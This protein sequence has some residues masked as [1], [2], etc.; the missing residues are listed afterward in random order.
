MVVHSSVDCPT[1][2]KYVRIPFHHPQQKD[3]RGK[4]EK[5]L[6]K[7]L[8]LVV[9]QDN[10]KKSEIP[11]T[12]MLEPIKEPLRHIISTTRGVLG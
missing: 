6:E 7:E 4:K 12:R 5:V 2:C 9:S 8:Y 1:N 3:Q 11:A 10:P